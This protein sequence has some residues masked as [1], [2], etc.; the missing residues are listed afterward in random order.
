M[1]RYSVLALFASVSA[2]LM[3]GCLM[4]AVQS[5]F[6]SSSTSLFLLF[7]LV[8]IS[9]MLNASMVFSCFGIYA[10]IYRTTGFDPIGSIFSRI[11][12]EEKALEKSVA[13]ALT[14]F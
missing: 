2:F 3:T 6:T 10:W 12:N 1:Y 14:R 13:E 5:A 7:G 9:Q 11:E 8:I 4:V